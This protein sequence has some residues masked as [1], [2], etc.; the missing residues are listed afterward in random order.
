[1]RKIEQE[2]YEG[3]LEWGWTVWLTQAQEDCP[4]GI[5]PAGSGRYGGTMRGSLTVVGEVAVLT[6]FIGGGGAASKYILRQEKDGS[7]NHT[8]G[9]SGFIKDSYEMHRAKI[10]PMVERHIKAV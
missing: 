3:I 10:I 7:L 4:V 5:Y 1:M 2:A 8:T 9:K 6:V